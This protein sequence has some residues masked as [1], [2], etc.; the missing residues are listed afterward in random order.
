MSEAEIKEEAKKRYWIEVIKTCKESGKP[1]TTWC[2]ENQI[3]KSSYWY[4]HKKLSQ[5]TDSKAVVVPEFAE[6]KEPAA[7]NDVDDTL[8]IEK[9]GIHIQVRRGISNELL[10]KLIRGLSNV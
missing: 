7:R 9:N 5:G 1:V 2:K 10:E 8:L 4:W 6:L 3:T